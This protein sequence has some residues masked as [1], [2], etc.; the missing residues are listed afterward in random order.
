MKILFR[1][2]CIAA[3]SLVVNNAS[4]SDGVNGA[5]ESP[6]LTAPPIIINLN[7][8]GIRP[9]VIDQCKPYLIIGTEGTFYN[10]SISVETTCK[11]ILTLENVWLKPEG[12]APLDVG[13]NVKLL[14]IGHNVL[15]G[16]DNNPGI[17]VNQD[18]FLYINQAEDNTDSITVTGGKNAAGIGGSN[19]KSSGTVTIGGGNITAQGGEAAAGIG[20]G[21][22][23]SNGSIN[24][25]GGTVSATGGTWGAGIGGGRRVKDGGGNGGNLIING[26]VITAKGGQYASGIG[27]GEGGT[28]GKIEIIDGTITA[29]GNFNAAGIG[30]ST[31]TKN[32][33]GNCLI[34]IQGGNVT[35]LA[36]KNGG[37]GI[38]AGKN[39]ALVTINGGT[40]NAIGAYGAGIGGGADENGGTVTINGGHVI[41][42]GGE[43]G[44]PV[45]HGS[46][47]IGGGPNSGGNAGNITITGGIVEASG[48][49]SGS[50]G[51]GGAG[52]GGGYA[53][54]G[55]NTMITGGTVNAFGGFNAAG[56]GGGERGHGG[57]VTIKGGTITAIGG[58][59]G[60]YSGAGIGGGSQTGFFQGGCGA[61]V[62]IAGGSIKA[63][64]GGPDA[65]DIG[66]GRI[67]ICDSGSLKNSLGQQVSKR[68]L[69]DAINPTNPLP[70]TLSIPISGPA[71]SYNYQYA[72][73]GHVEYGRP[74]PNLYFYLPSNAPVTP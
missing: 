74:D 50:A 68:V 10:K 56:I 66:H 27:A 40:V 54:T 41:A 52:I 42:H 5:D 4:A 13:M 11:V 8:L 44:G 28:C 49:S 32:P 1:L 57:W 20:G 14:L 12:Q 31:N 3:S 60:P 58:G 64:R 33:I 67:L 65:E 37:A 25:D 26:G 72:G 23:G 62:T 22:G 53:G 15:T 43:G 45:Y 69:T 48:G 2:I 63:V 34:T 36:G 35:A 17:K 73:S 70:V 51:G 9:I 39:G 61:Q 16:S 47:G 71:G 38:G 7:E 19:G 6:P 59:V 21:N 30:N 18:A 29:E 46:A 55:A 24:I